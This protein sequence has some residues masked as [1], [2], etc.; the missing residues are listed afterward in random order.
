MEVLSTQKRVHP[1][2]TQ[3]A[4]AI[5]LII[6]L[7]LSFQMAYSKG[8]Q[9]DDLLQLELAVDDQLTLVV[10]AGWRQDASTPSDEVLLRGELSGMAGEYEL[11]ALRLAEFRDGSLDVV[12]ERI[13]VAGGMTLSATPLQAVS[14]LLDNQPVLMGGFSWFTADGY[15]VYLRA[16]MVEDAAGGVTALGLRAIG[17]TDEVVRGVLRRIAAQ[18]KFS[19]M[20]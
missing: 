18:A 8:H 15:S 9:W 10:P 19:V 5:L 6:A 17:G 14:C 16:I 4:C 7:L 11:R 3:A 20:G 2:R 13:V 12:W 1:A